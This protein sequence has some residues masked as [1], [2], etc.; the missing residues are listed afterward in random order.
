MNSRSRRPASVSLRWA[1][2][3]SRPASTLPPDSTITVRPEGAGVTRPL[4]S[5]ATPTAPPP[6]T[7]SFERSSSQTIASA[8]SSSPTTTMSST[9]R[10]DE[11]QR[12]LARPLDRDPVGDRRARLERD[13]SVPTIESGNGA[14]ASTWT[15]ITR[16]EGGALDDAGD[17]GD[18]PAAAD[19]DD[20]LGEIGHVLEQ[21]EAERRLTEDH[22]GVVERVHE[23]DPGLGRARARRGDARVDR[24]AAEVDDPAERLDGGDLG[25]RRLVGHEHLARDPLRARRVRERLAVIAGAAGDHPGHARRAARSCEWRRG[26]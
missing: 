1:I 3:A 25:D 24:V 23:S 21:L 12:Q 4:S 10:C 13:R 9:Q 14:Q 5:A 19:R 17:P 22:V 20:D 15:P 7:T 26:A 8:T 18:Q 2:A 11:R 16:A 6:S